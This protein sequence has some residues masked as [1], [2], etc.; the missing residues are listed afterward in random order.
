MDRRKFLER[1]GLLSTLGVGACATTMELRANEPKVGMGG[2]PTAA[3]TTIAAAQ[4]HMLPSSISSPGALSVNAIGY[5]DA[6][7]RQG[8]VPPE[9]LASL[10]RGAEAL[11]K[12]AGGAFANAPQKDALLRAYQKTPDGEAWMTAVLSYALE[13]LL[14]DPIHG[15]NPGGIAWA[16]AGIRPPFPRPRK[17]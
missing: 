1:S 2:L 14:G 13:A 4:E 12:R 6:A 16:W 3:R 17:Q 7:I 8:A 5:L 9:Q 10:I 11:D 15:G